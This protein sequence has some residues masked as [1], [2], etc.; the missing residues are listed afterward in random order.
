M[1]GHS[2]SQQVT[3]GHSRLSH[4]AAAPLVEAVNEP[5]GG[6][7]DPPARGRGAVPDS[8]SGLSVEL[9]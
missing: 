3:V 2:R 9:Y 5:L 6:D 7:S 4:L 8:Q 1:L